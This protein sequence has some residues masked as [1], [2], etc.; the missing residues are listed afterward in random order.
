MNVILSF[1]PITSISPLLCLCPPGGGSV[2]AA[3]FGYVSMEPAGPSSSLYVFLATAV[4]ITDL[5]LLQ[6]QRPAYLKG[7]APFP[8]SY[9]VGPATG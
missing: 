9:Q 1:V 6:H 4:R 7:E 5:L 2:W 3:S 8:L